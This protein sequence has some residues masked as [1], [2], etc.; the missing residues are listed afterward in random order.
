MSLS[1]ADKRL[2]QR[3]EQALTELRLEGLIDESYV[4]GCVNFGRRSAAGL[5]VCYL[6]VEFGDHTGE[7]VSVK[8]RRPVAQ[9]LNRAIVDEIR[10]QIR[11][12]LTNA[13]EG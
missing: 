12:F 5:E 2:K 8:F 7:P 1:S 4:I 3:G 11:R 13:A 6:E 9:D 10:S